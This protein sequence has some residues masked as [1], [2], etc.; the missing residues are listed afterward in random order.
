MIKLLFSAVFIFATISIKANELD[1]KFNLFLDNYIES[2]EFQR[3][4]TKIPLEKL[5]IDPA[6]EPE[7]KTIESVLAQNK[8]VFPLIQSKKEQLKNGLKF[9]I[10]E[11]TSND[12]KAFLFKEDTG[13][14]VLY[15]FKKFGN[16]WQLVRIED[17]SL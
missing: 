5:T 10:M 2:I 3:Q 17:H 15:I 14:Q 4:H 1:T 8:V 9:K 11:L 6:A 7:P 16:T 12:A 13:W